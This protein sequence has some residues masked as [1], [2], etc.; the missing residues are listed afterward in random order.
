MRTEDCE[1]TTVGVLEHR[2]NLSVGPRSG[3]GPKVFWVGDLGIV[4]GFDSR[5][6]S[7]GFFQRNWPAVGHHGRVT[8]ETVRAMK[9]TTEHSERQ[10]VAAG[11]GV[12]K[13]LLLDRIALH[14]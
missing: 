7:K 10:G 1:A 13:G 12:E 3:D 5:G 6:R 4:R 14:A 11:V 9:I 2:P 8:R